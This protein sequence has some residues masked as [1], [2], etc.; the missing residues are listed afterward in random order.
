MYRTETSVTLHEN[1]VCVIEADKGEAAATADSMWIKQ[2]HVLHRQVQ[3]SSSLQCH[4]QK[5]ENNK[6]M[7]QGPGPLLPT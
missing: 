1:W 4:C 3:R 6:V 2:L 5:V 7:L